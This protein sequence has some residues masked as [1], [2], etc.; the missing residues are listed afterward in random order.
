MKRFVL[1]CLITFASGS[2]SASW[3]SPCPTTVYRP[4]SGFYV[5][6]GGGVATNMADAAFISTFTIGGASGT[7]I[8]DNDFYQ[9]RPWG[10]VY[11]GWGWQFCWLYLGARVGA[12]FSQYD[13]NGE[14]LLV[15]AATDV[16]TLGSTLTTKLQAT[17]YTFDFKPGVVFCNNTMFFGIF[18]AAVNKERM[19]GRMIFTNS[20]NPVLFSENELKRSRSSAA[21][22]GGAGIEHLFCECLSIHLMYVYTNYWELQKSTSATV[23]AF[24]LTQIASTKAH[25]QVTSAGLTFYF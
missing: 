20:D 25:K 19:E 5:G 18:G 2:L 24:T 4:F 16:I 14:A 13:P 22:R 11:G 6:V 17:E 9:V 15:N 12:N 21:L 1:A 7:L 10:E 8:F 23:G 3:F